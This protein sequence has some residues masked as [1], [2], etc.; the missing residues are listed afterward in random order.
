MQ[1]IRDL[2]RH[3]GYLDADATYSVTPTRKNNQVEVTFTIHEG[4][5][6]H[7][8]AVQ[9]EGVAVYPLKDLRKKV[10]SRPGRIFDPAFLQLDT[11]LISTLYQERGYRPHVTAAYRRGQPDSVHVDVTYSVREG[12]RYRVGEVTVSGQDQVKDK[13]IQREL[14]LKPNDVHQLSRVSRTQERLYRDRSVPAGPH[15]AA[16][17]LDPDADELRRAAARAQA[18]LGRS[19]GRQQHR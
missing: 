17:R 6:T 10:W 15:R 4:P 12:Q 2:Y 8:R 1:S 13:L 7:L 9:F 5:I 19:F 3:N 16:A 18:A 11:L 14:L